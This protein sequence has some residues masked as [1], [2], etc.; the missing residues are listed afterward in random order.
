[1]SLQI[2]GSPRWKASTIGKPKPS[3]RDAINSA[4]ALR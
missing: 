1:M 2:T 4:E 3:T